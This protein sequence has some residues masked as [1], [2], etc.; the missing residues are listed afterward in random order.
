MKMFINIVKNS[1]HCL[2]W[3]TID[4]ERNDPDIY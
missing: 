3:F 2:D 4:L 1:H